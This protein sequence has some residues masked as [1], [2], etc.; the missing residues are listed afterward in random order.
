MKKVNGIFVLLLGTVFFAFLFSACQPSESHA[1]G[2]EKK[3][4]PRHDL[5]KYFRNHRKLLVVYAGE[6]AK[7]DSVYLEYLTAVKERF[8]RWLELDIKSLNEVPDSQLVDRAVMLIGTP[9]S[10]PFLENVDF[11]LPFRLEKR[12]FSFEEELY[13]DKR[14]SL[15]LSFIP[16]P[17]SPHIPLH[18]LIGN[19]DEAILEKVKD[20]GPGM[21]SRDLWS[22]Y[23]YEIAKG[24][25]QLLIGLFGNDWQ[26]EKEKQWDFREGDDEVEGKY[27]SLKTNGFQMDK[28]MLDS[29]N[30]LLES[31]LKEVEN[32]MGEEPS[33]RPFQLELYKDAELM[34]LMTRQMKQGFYDKEQRVVHQ[35]HHPTLRNRASAHLFYP[36]FEDLMGEVND[37]NTFLLEGLS[38]AF[39]PSWMGQSAKVWGIRLYKAGGLMGLDI[40]MNPEAN[41][42]KSIYSRAVSAASFV[43]YLK[44]N[45]PDLLKA[46]IKDFAS[47]KSKLKEAEKKWMTYLSEVEAKPPVFRGEQQDFY[48]GMTFAHEGYN[49]YNGYASQL[50]NDALEEISSLHANSI[51]IVPYSG[52][53]NTSE[54][55]EYAVWEGAGSENTMSVVFAAWH[56]KKHGMTS[57]LKPQIYYGGAWPGAVQ[58]KNRQDWE[59]WHRY[60]KDWI[61]HYA[62][63]AEIYGFDALCVGVEFTHA[64]LENP[65]LWED[66]IESVRQIYAGPITYAANWGEEAEKIAFADK[67]DY[68]GVNSYY[69]L[70]DKQNPTEEELKQGAEAIMSRMSKLSSRIQ[71]PIVFTEIGFRS[72]EQAWLNPHAEANGKATSNETQARLYHQM[73]QAMDG[74]AWCRGMYWWKWPSYMDYSMESPHSF[75]PCGKA[76]ADTLKSWFGKWE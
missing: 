62:L 38:A 73:L 76:A 58:M 66:I 14:H 21:F 22:D 24:K 57:L 40:L 19:S 72:V 23:G 17:V 64:T 3:L 71:K 26:V 41:S 46:L 11:S 12:G 2:I 47:N 30:M 53:R 56:A 27:V 31:S 4:P 28:H 10:I 59:Q 65:D 74:E 51:A 35:I 69:P 25:K 54:P 61:L 6:N 50:G 68:M 5:L 29:L 52:S 42:R 34:G 49:V 67:L 63:V 55:V 8:N 7:T 20:A 44:E 60:Y 9:E 13:K 43:S 32:F 45:Q 70:S 36:F 48:K 75:T 37:E 15:S 16:N 39:C 33:F 18:L 1:Q